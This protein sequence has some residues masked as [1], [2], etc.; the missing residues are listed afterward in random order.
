MWVL[1]REKKEIAHVVQST[2]TVTVS[3][4]LDRRVGALCD[5]EALGK[6]DRASTHAE[7]IWATL[8]KGRD[9]NI[10]EGTAWV[11]SESQQ[12]LNVVLS[13]AHV[14]LNRSTADR[15]HGAVGSDSVGATTRE[16]RHIV[17]VTELTLLGVGHL[18]VSCGEGH[19]AGEDSELLHG[20]GICGVLFDGGE[21]LL[22]TGTQVREQRGR[23]MSFKGAI[24]VV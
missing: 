22:D 10:V 1:C 4:D 19:Q 16:L 8:G 18:P 15:E 23:H 6:L 20:E 13:V 11:V 9:N 12:N 5:V 17:L 7:V 14:E 24:P 21:E 2:T 3:H